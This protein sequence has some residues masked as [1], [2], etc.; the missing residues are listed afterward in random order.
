[1][2]L[3]EFTDYH[4]PFCRRHA[5]NTTPSLIKDYVETGKIR[6]GIRELPLE[7]LHPRA[8][9]LAQA[10]I[11]A[12]QQGK[13]WIMHDLFFEKKVTDVDASAKAAKLN[14]SIFS[15]CTNDKAVEKQI[16]EG[17]KTAGKLG[18]RGT[19]G[20]ILGETNTNTPNTL[21]ALQ[22]L[23]GTFAVRPLSS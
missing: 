13:Y 4:C 23:R 7:S 15:T 19:P 10:A 6:Y 17:I 3:V 20:F 14:M 16:R 2:T 18:I 12:G 11:C 1:M 8:F 9:K 21:H 22:S 5:Q